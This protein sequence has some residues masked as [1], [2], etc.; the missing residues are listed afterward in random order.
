MNERKVRK[1][2]QRT[3]YPQR[4]GRMWRIP[5]VIA[6]ALIPAGLLAI[7]S[8][9]PAV[10]AVGT[11][12]AVAAAKASATAL[13]ASGAAGP[14]GLNDWRD[15]NELP[16]S[17]VGAQT[18]MF[19][20]F[21]RTGAN[22]D[23]FDGTYSCLR[24]TAQGCVIAVDHGAGEIDMLW[25]TRGGPLTANGNLTVILDGKTVIDAPLNDVVNGDLGAPFVYPLVA[26]YQQDSGGSYIYVP[27]TYAK[28]M[29]VIT[30]YN[31]GFYQVSY[32][33][34]ASAAG[35]TTFN[36]K[37]DRASDVIAMLKAAGTKDPISPLPKAVTRTVRFG[38]ARGT[39]V[40]LARLDGPGEISALRMNIPSLL[41]MTQPPQKISYGGRGFTSGGSSQFTVKIKPGNDGVRLVRRLDGNVAD[42]VADVYVDGHLAG[43]WKPLPE[44]WGL[45]VPETFDIPASVTKGKSQLTIKNTF[46]SA[47]FTQGESQLTMKNTPSASNFTEYGY[48]VYSHVGGHWLQTDKFGQG[49]GNTAQEKAHSYT[50]TKGDLDGTDSREQLPST[51]DQAAVAATDDILENARIEISFDGQQTVNVPLGQ[52]F[53]VGLGKWRVRSLFDAVDGGRGG[54]MSSWWPM[55]YAHSA[56][57]TLVNDSSQPISS[58][59]AQI[60][61]APDAQWAAELGPGGQAGYFHATY[62]YG[63]TTP[64]RDV[65]WLT[66]TGTG[67]LVGVFMT[68][69]GADPTQGREYMEGDQHVYID[70]SRTPQ[71]N[72]TGTED[73]AMGG[74]YFSQGMFTGPV[75]GDPW[76]QGAQDGCPGNCTGEYRLWIPDAETFTSNIVAGQEHGG[77]D[78][79]PADYGTIAFWYGRPQVT[80]VQ[81]DSLTVGDAA[82][83]AA[84][85]YS[86]ATMCTPQQVT[87]TYEGDDGPYNGLPPADYTYSASQL[88][89]PVSFTMQI[90]SA[91][92][93]VVLERTSS[94]QDGYQ[95][96]EVYVDGQDAGEWEQPLANPY[97]QWL[98]DSFALAA[99]LTSGRAQLSIE[100]VYV[101]GAF[102]WNAAS[103]RAIS[104]VTGGARGSSQPAAPSSPPPAAPAPATTDCS[105]VISSVTPATAS[106][107]Q[108]VTITGTGFGSTQGQGFV[109]LTDD[110]I[111]FGPPAAWFWLGSGLSSLNGAATLHA[112][113]T[114]S[115]GNTSITFTMPAAGGKM[116]LTPATVAS[117]TV[118]S[119]LGAVS[120]TTSVTIPPS[121]N[122]ADYYDGVGISN[123]SDP[124][125][126]NFD[127][128]GSSYSAQALAAAGLTPGKAVTAGGIT[129]TWPDAPAGQPDMIYAD[130]QTIAVSGSGAT[131]GF[132][133]AAHSGSGSG[134]GTI[135]YTDGTTQQFTLT[136]SD[137][138]ANAAPPGGGIVAS[139]PYLNNPR[140]RVTQKNSVYYELIPLQP[141]KAVEDVTL[142]TISNMDIFALAIG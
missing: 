74:Y 38:A 124:K 21:D 112:L 64:G 131:L 20:S 139:M 128:S 79:R 35:V 26:N 40:T 118:I 39:S 87:S 16:V 94:Q 33:H 106:A 29:E 91:N 12:S 140:R 71:I 142:P 27:M 41:G 109:A 103:Y 82:S 141:G 45:W 122:L 116:G 136:F 121:S 44:Q 43:S 59:E 10:A 9:A 102:A 130:H 15:L 114:D 76:Q 32:R 110:G 75:S 30:Q 3:G 28:S 36:P 8:Q 42:Q 53:G 17:Q 98:D 85:H 60:T 84:H 93:G 56:T 90:D 88:D 49:P 138:W 89:T 55:P 34:F 11:A 113:T 68:M 22:N 119:S 52:F 48:Q 105:A 135:T 120:D 65:N 115:W 92:Q 127:G 126:A 111:T 31:P 5:A 132:L 18:R 81:T 13:A 104:L 80:G 37:A 62:H 117:V 6:T 100:L 24:Q 137:W 50:I 25:F 107:G 97:H 78:Q 7:T 95:A 86:A 23:G 2:H 67:K 66:A 58:S 47:S 73:I 99:S 96:V 108:Q 77:V 70:G 61:S 69:E 14:I 125:S 51:T 83:Q 123:D 72:G 129:Y 133:G 57:I 54:W 19:S 63:P 46:V 1:S 134:T 101:P 4:V